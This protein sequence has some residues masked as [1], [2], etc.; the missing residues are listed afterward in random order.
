[1]IV[2]SQIATPLPRSLTPRMTVAEG[3]RW[4]ME[5]GVH[6]MPVVDGTGRAIGV[7]STTD[8]A[9]AALEGALR[10]TVQRWMSVPPLS[11]EPGATLYEAIR[12]MVRADVRR[13]LV[14]DGAGRPAGIVTPTDLLR[15]E[16]NL[17][18]GFRLR[19]PEDPKEERTP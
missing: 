9:R 12:T 3:G 2:V 15:A 17:A 4:M 10:E 6:G 1:M 14:L 8:V 19:T 7:L 11:I 13:L 5:D 16:A 18:E